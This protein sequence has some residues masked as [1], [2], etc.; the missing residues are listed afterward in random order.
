MSKG[1]G[2]PLLATAPLLLW[3]VNCDCICFKP[4]CLQL[5]PK[6]GGR[7]WPG[8]E[9]CLGQRAE[10]ERELWHGASVHGGACATATRL[11]LAAPAPVGKK[12]V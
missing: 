3:G 1:H 5:L 11:G 4:S 8:S 2:P 12:H 9:C 7:S 6:A 10:R